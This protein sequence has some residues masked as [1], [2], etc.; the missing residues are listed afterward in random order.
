M[1][2]FQLF[3]LELDAFTVQLHVVLDIVFDAGSH[4]KDTSGLQFFKDLVL[5]VNHLLLH[6]G[7][8][9]RLELV[10]H[11]L[12][13]WVF[14]TVHFYFDDAV[15]VTVVPSVFGRWILGV[16]LVNY[17]LL[18]VSYLVLELSNVFLLCICLH[19][20]LFF[21]VSERCELHDQLVVRNL[22]IVLLV[23]QGVNLI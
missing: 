12:F 11:W 4:D 2:F 10:V 13:L 16:E 22:N 6:D 23:C 8:L 7:H 19:C 20:Q 21:F 17:L 3:Q 9:L 5:L 14:V 1:A 18:K 15:V